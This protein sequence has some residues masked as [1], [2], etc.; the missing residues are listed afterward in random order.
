MR[1]NYMDTQVT[2]KQINISIQYMFLLLTKTVCV[3]FL[4]GEHI[5]QLLYLYSIKAMQV[6]S[7]EQDRQTIEFVPRG[8][9]LLSL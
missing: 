6:H 9:K 4:I 2:G 1:I 3:Y 7:H 8:Y 5:Y